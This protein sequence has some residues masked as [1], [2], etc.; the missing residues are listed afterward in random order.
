MSRQDPDD[1]KRAPAMTADEQALGTVRGVLWQS[2]GLTEKQVRA[3]CKGH[4]YDEVS[5]AIGV[6]LHDG[7]VKQSGGREPVYIWRPG[8]T[9]PHLPSF[10]QP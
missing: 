3:A 10:G 7:A 9:G 8:Y 6:L 1:R 5:R 4:G 2:D